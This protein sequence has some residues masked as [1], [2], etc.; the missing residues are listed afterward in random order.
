MIATES[1]GA[2][3]YVAEFIDA[4]LADYYNHYECDTLFQ[5]QLDVIA[6]ESDGATRYVAE[7]IDASL[8]D[9]YNHYECDKGNKD[10]QK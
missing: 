5:C 10:N 4:F 3:R 9:Y 2:T 6:T 8:A 7:F 1:D